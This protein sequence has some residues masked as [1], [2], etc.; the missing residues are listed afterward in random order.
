[1]HMPNPMGSRADGA[2]L[3]FAPPPSPMVTHPELPTGMGGNPQGHD[4]AIGETPFLMG[5]SPFL[6]ENHWLTMGLY[7]YKYCWLVVFRLFL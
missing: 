2:G 3:A 6:M 7:Y 5:K 4:V 1:M